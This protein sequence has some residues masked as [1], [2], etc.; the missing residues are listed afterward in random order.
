M[1]ITLRVTAILGGGGGG[2]AFKNKLRFIPKPSQSILVPNSLLSWR[3][4]L[5]VNRVVRH[6]KCHS[7]MGAVKQPFCLITDCRSDRLHGLHI[8]YVVYIQ[9]IRKKHA[10]ECRLSGRRNM[11]HVALWANFQLYCQCRTVSTVHPA[12]SKECP[13]ILALVHTS[14][15]TFLH[16][17]TEAFKENFL[18]PRTTFAFISHFLLRFQN[19]HWMYRNSVPQISNNWS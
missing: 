15:N 2:W 9:Q 3:S 6:K 10:F 1:S 12:Y 11:I 13:V 4:H 8:K 16:Y 18:S 14:S 17:I 7:Y 5:H 19:R